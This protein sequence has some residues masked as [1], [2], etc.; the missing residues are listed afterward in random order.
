VIRLRVERIG[1]QLRDMLSGKRPQG[2]LV[3]DHPG[4]A[5]RLELPHQRMVGSE[6]VVSIRSDDQQVP[7]V[8]PDQRFDEIER[9]GVEPLQIVEKERERPLRAGEHLNESLE[10]HLKSSACLLGRHIGCGR[11]FS[12]D[13]L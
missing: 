6:F 3:H 7:D 13:Q 11:L 8:A 10:N 9:G 1:D 2:D 4:L 12:D 5:N